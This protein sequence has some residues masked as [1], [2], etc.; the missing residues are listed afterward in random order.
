MHS[1]RPFTS[2]VPNRPGARGGLPRAPD[3]TGR[4]SIA[5]PGQSKGRAAIFGQ[6]G[7]PCRVGHVSSGHGGWTAGNGR[8]RQGTAGDGRGRQ[9][10]AGDG[11]GRQGTAGDGRGRQGMA[12]DGRGLSEMTGNGEGRRGTTGDA[13][14]RHE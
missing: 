12:E 11:R 6:D 13:H 4:L 14:G 10:T 9:G 2:S 3:G 5:R 7:R 8:G 1:T